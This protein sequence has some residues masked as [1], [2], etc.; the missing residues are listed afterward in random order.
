MRRV[1]PLLLLFLLAAPACAQKPKFPATQPGRRL[2]RLLDAFNTGTADYIRLFIAEN[3]SDA[4]LKQRSAQDRTRAYLD[5]YRNTHGVSLRRID[6]SDDTEI[7]AVVQTQLSGEWLR[8][9]CRVE[10]EKPYKIAGVVFSSIPTPPEFAPKGKLSD[11]DIARQ[12]SAYTEKLVKEG[13]FSGVVLV[14]RGDRPIFEAAYGK[15]DHSPATMDTL[16]PLASITKTFVAVAVAQLVDQGKLSFGDPVS[17]FFHDYPGEARDQ[18]TVH[19]LLTHSAGLPALLDQREH[20]ELKRRN[21]RTGAQWVQYIGSQP[22]A[23]LP[24]QGF[25]YSNAGYILLDAVIT[26]VSGSPAK[27]RAQHIF[28]PL[29]MD[30]TTVDASTA[31]DLLRFSVGLRAGKLLSPATFSLMTSPQVATN[32]PAVRYGY[33]LEIEDV[34]GVRVIGHPGGGPHASSQLD[35]YPDLDITVVVLST[36][37][38]GAAQHVSN[39]LRDLITQR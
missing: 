22:L 15:A 34:N 38:R 19:H 23:F 17:K 10:P 32:D 14:A 16:F 9:S 12:A 13:I 35:I 36:M 18:I 26:M 3:Y 37:P 2:A 30:H 11:D 33:G 29:G 31:H 39:R 5:L 27:Y 1:I 24:G 21:L 28:R 7:V 6:V 20:D 25:Q 8:I 4:A